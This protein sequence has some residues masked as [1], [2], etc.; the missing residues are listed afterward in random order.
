MVTTLCLVRHG[1]TEG[2]DIPRYKGSLDVPLSARGYEQVRRTAGRLREV[3]AVML[4]ERRQSYLRVVHDQEGAANEEGLDVVYCSPLSRAVQSAEL[5][6]APHGL[7]P[8]V[9]D[10]LRERHFG[11]WEGLSFAEIKRDFPE[12]FTAWAA[13]PVR[14][15][16]PEGENTQEVAH[17]GRTA[18]EAILARHPGRN[19]G[20]VAHGGINRV[21]LCH[22]LGMPLENIFRLEQDLACFNIIEMWEQLPVVKLLNAL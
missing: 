20:V 5:I 8:V 19:V 4:Q 11:V 22:L 9:E 6:A 13:D 16:P 7:T 1:E 3:L 12:A 18:L 21:I 14:F 15:A 17:R 2:S 10:D